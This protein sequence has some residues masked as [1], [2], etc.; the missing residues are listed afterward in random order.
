MLYYYTMSDP[1]GLSK[2]NPVQLRL[3]IILP[4]SRNIY[5]MIDTLTFLVLMVELEHRMQFN[6]SIFGIGHPAESVI[7]EILSFA[8]SGS[9]EK[10]PTLVENCI[11]QV[12]QLLSK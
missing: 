8:R 5:D 7:N 2:I 1:E 4:E 6:G 9:L 10:N 12:E 11:T 3:P